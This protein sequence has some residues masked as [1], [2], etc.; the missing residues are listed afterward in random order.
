[1]SV[2]YGSLNV[3][4]KYSSILEPNL[5]HD[6][7]FADGMTFTSKYED[8]PA[9]GIFVHKLGTSAVAV[10]TPG[11]D[12]QDEAT[13]DTL[14]PIVLNNNFM[15]S[16]KIYGVQANAVALNLANEQLS[17]A[18]KEVAEGNTLGGL[19]CLVHEGTASANQGTSLTTSNIKAQIL[20]DRKAIR[21]AK[22]SADVLL[23][24]TGA[25]AILLE[26]FGSEFTPVAND[27]VNAN[28]QIAK[29]LGFT[30]MECSAL[31]EASADY[32]DYTGTKQTK[33]LNGV[34]YIMYNHEALSIVPNFDVARIVDSENFNGSKAQVELNVG[35][36]VTSGAQVVIH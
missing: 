18:T 7:V 14:I 28:G 21:D 35:Y 24:S 10:G 13:A 29:W 19:A 30:V 12:F 25:F 16:K 9:G 1:M 36:R 6:S 27:Y 34:D 2:I 15:K 3:D 23:M 22:G 11:R 8:G 17:I 4:E 5:Y 26:K 32:Y 31:S 20:A 33:A